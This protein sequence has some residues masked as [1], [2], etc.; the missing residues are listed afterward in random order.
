MNRNETIHLLRMHAAVI[1]NFGATALHLYGSGARDE[2]RPD[3]DIDLFIDYD[4][5]GPFS[6]VELIRL[7]RYL[8]AA[9]KRDVDITTRAGLHPALRETIERSSMRVL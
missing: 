2:L 1:R 5:E 7:E 4:P 9:L 8:A 6:F 3:S